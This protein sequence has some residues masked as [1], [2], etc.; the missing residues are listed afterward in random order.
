MHELNELGE[1]EV[2]DGRGSC[3][4]PPRSKQTFLFQKEKS[5]VSSHDGIP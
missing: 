1:V 4:S 5:V 3:K 2:M